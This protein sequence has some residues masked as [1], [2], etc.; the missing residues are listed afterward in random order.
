MCF[1]TCLRRSIQFAGVSTLL[2]FL[3]AAPAPAD[4][5]VYAALPP[6]IRVL[7]YDVG[8][9]TGDHRKE[10][11]VLYTSDGSTSLALFRA[12]SGRWSKWA[13]G[14]NSLKRDDGATA[15]SM[16]LTD[17][18]GDGTD[19]ILAY[20]LTSGDTAMVTRVLSIDA[21]GGGPPAFRNILE[22]KTVPP[23]YPLLGTEG[24]KPSVTFLQMG[25][26]NSSGLRRVYC[27]D[28]KSFEQCVEVVWKKP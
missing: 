28:G 14:D 27:W 4:P 11:A 16:E 15:R 23:G 22:D 9:V 5:D 17:T 21:N 24:S 13:D 25:S 20:Y 3:T 18:N 10:L 7:Q 2:L 6:G 19:E 1:P 26:R 12:Q 8:D